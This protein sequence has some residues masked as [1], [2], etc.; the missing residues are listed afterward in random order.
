M[1]LFFSFGFVMMMIM[2][3]VMMMVMGIGDFCGMYKLYSFFVSVTCTVRYYYSMLEST[4]Q[5]VSYIFWV[6]FLSAK[7]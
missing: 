7:D 3:M 6:W 5:C 2:M 4:F 1:S